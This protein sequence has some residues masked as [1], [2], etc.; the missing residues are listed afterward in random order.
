MLSYPKNVR[1]VVGPECVKCDVGGRH[2]SGVQSFSKST[3]ESVNVKSLLQLIAMVGGYL[4]AL[5]LTPAAEKTKTQAEN[6]SQKLN[7]KEALASLKKS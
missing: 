2:V 6:S 5:F 3:R 7:L 4:Q 1:C